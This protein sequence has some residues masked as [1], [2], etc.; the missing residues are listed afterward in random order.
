[1]RLEH[2]HEMVV[3]KSGS[4]DLSLELFTYVMHC[5]VTTVLFAQSSRDLLELLPLVLRLIKWMKSARLEHQSSLTL[6]LHA[7]SSSSAWPGIL[8]L[9]CHAL[10]ARQ[11]PQHWGAN[12]L[13]HFLVCYPAQHETEVQRC[14]CTDRGAFV[15]RSIF[16]V[17]SHFR[18]GQHLA[19]RYAWKLTVTRSWL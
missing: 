18:G 1:M 16:S 3:L 6:S 7:S 2:L 4:A 5:T 8:T 12:V 10:H 9:P 11:S 17:L 15:G 14:S 13:M 19:T